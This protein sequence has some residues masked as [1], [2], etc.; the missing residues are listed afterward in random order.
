MTVRHMPIKEQATKVQ[1]SGFALAK[2]NTD[3]KN[4]DELVGRVDG[5][6]IRNKT[7]GVSCPS[8]VLS[9]PFGSVWLVLRFLTLMMSGSM[10]SQDPRSGNRLPSVDSGTSI[11]S[12]PYGSV[13]LFKEGLKEGPTKEGHCPA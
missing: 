5:V 9:Q 2:R 7:T 4:T 3:N 12:F 8:P 1:R 10:K 11:L 13:F 6:R